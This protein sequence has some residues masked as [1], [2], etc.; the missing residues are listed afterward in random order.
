MSE[1]RDG[2]TI[3]E[4]WAEAVRCHGE[5]PFLIIPADAGRSYLAGGLE[6]S[7]AEANGEVERLMTIY[8]DAGYG[9]GHRVALLLDNRPEHLLHRL[10]L[11][12]L[13]VSCVPINPDYRPAEI[14]YL[15]DHAEPELILVLRA[16]TRQIA[17]ALAQCE[18]QPH[19]QVLEQVFAPPSPHRYAQQA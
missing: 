14:A 11:N 16:R 6:I 18:R 4:V 3:G 1:L 9:L 2:Q 7:Y 15:I 5:R 8:A 13:G 12:A 17:D 19:V 10:A